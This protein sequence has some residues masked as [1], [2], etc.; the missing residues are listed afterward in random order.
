MYIASLHNI[1]AGYNHTAAQNIA[2][3]FF[4]FI[5]GVLNPFITFR[6]PS[7]DF[8]WQ[9]Y[10]I[11][12]ASPPRSPLNNIV[13]FCLAPSNEWMNPIY[14]QFLVATTANWLINRKEG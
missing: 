13:D 12:G 2:L 10:F 8:G 3:T 4:W 7:I 5:F 11:S 1:T 6:V 9:I 14:H